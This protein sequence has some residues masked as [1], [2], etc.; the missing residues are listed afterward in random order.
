MNLQQL[1]LTARL[2]AGNSNKLIVCFGADLFQNACKKI[3]YAHGAKV[4]TLAGADG[5]RAVF[6]FLVSDNEHIGRFFQLSFA[7]PVTDFFAAQI[8]RCAQT[9]GLQLL[10]NGIG[11]VLLTLGDR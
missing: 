11:A 4:L 7:D 5:N 3:F 1:L 8:G 2:Q 9:G 6:N 10:K